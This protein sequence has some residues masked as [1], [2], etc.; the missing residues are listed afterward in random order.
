[1]RVAF[2]LIGGRDWTGGYNYLLNLLRVL[3]RHP[4]CGIAPVLFVP[5]QLPAD[6]LKPFLPLLAQPPVEHAV[7]ARGGAVA[8][9][10]RACT[11][12]DVPEVSRLFLEQ[13]ID[14]A[15][16]AAQF[17]G[18]RFPVPTL[19]WTPD[20]QHR[21]LP[22]MFSRRA[23]LR[24]EIGY[25]AQVSAGRTLMLSSEDAR[26]DSQRF[27]PE[28][29]GRTIVVRFAVLPPAVPTRPGEELLQKYGLPERFLYLPNQFW[30]HK[31][32]AVVIEALAVLARDGREVV[33][34][35][36]G[37]PNDARHADHFRGLQA[38]IA[39]RGV[40]S[41]FRILG[42]LP[43]EDVV[44][45]TTLCT[46]LVN[47]S[48]FEGWST[49][50]EEAKA[51]GADLV[52]SDLGV[53]REQAG[54]GAIYFDPASPVSAARALLTAWTRHPS[55]TRAERSAHA[56]EASHERVREFAHAFARA[57]R[58]AREQR[59][60]RQRGGVGRLAPVIEFPPRRPASAPK[61]PL[62]LL[63]V[64]NFYR[65]ATP[66][67]EDNAFRQERDLLRQAGVDV[68][69]FT[70][71]NDDVDEF[72]PVQAARTGLELS[73]SEASYHELARLIRR[74]RP[75]VAHFHNTF[76]L[77]SPSGYQACRDH[78]VPV[79]Q[80]L[81]NYRFTCAAG[82][83]Y[84]DGHVCEEC[85]GRV[86][87]AGVR[88]RC[89]RDSLAGSA[90]VGWMLRSNWA[91][92]TYTDLVDL[93]VTLTQFAADH[94][95][96][97]GLP[98]DRLVVNPNFAESTLPPGRGDGRYVIFAARLAEEKGV[99]TIVEAWRDLRDIP[100]KIVGE[101]P[102]SDE[103]ARAVR[104]EE[105]PIELLGMRRR[106]D[107]LQLMGDA[108]FQVVASRWYEGHP[109]VIVESYARGTPVIASRIG[110]LVEL[111]APGETGL[112]FD[113]N[114][115]MDLR[116][117]VRHLW[118]D[119]ALRTRMRAGARA[120]YLE[121]YTPEAALQ[122]LLQIYSRVRGAGRYDPAL[123]SRPSA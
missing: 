23:W 72:N 28:S 59:R 5:P 118:N 91:R 102:L 8:R 101:G 58:M 42:M 65:S 47:P 71:S 86:P 20:F 93:Y 113:P 82:T 95:V 18:W 15:F 44:G 87:W 66:G 75:D 115:V 64:H 3:D 45:L 112:H 12:G 16:E 22:Q 48:F 79:V 68:V 88:H 84:R 46:A 36:S 73:W 14:V 109:L 13:Q 78:G 80:T 83:H 52:L 50:V 9:L 38:L 94:F 97:A 43:Y 51:L 34:A 41:Q 49:T 35:A 108:T 17:Y 27:Y 26:Q 40:E 100:L 89:Y 25:R 122:R 99:R 7:F 10:A 117:K 53:H 123:S 116:A 67:G 57:A 11:L 76:P 119:E 19:A 85:T 61:P 21:H 6:Y 90:A 29:A 110:G 63:L 37:N 30:K 1:M 81:H 60:A 121:R 107:V 111:V 56:A 39:E 96:A 77:I 62:K 92:G 106:A 54:E 104:E 31:N 103:L 33:V 120:R 114:S 70:R 55:T 4:D 105:L 32:H 2:T 24:R 98:A 74:E 69:T